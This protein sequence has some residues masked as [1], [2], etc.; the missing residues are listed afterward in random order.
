MTAAKFRL[1]NLSVIADYKDGP[2]HHSVL[3]LALMRA[4]PNMTVVVPGDGNELKRMIPA[5]AEHDGPVYFR[6]CTAMD[7]DS[8][9]DHF[10]FRPEDIAHAAR[11]ILKRK[12]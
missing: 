6:I 8:I 9:L 5:I 7:A 4:L 2:T 10:G 1:D 12:H 3:D 11:E